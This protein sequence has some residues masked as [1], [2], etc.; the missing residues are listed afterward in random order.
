M[1]T[2]ALCAAYMAAIAAA[3]SQADAASQIQAK[4]LAPT[5]VQDLLGYTPAHPGANSDI[6][7]LS[8]LTTFSASG[9]GSVGGNLSVGGSAI[10]LSPSGNSYFNGGY[11]GI[12]YAPGQSLTHTLDLVGTFGIS[13]GG[14]GAM[15]Q[16]GYDLSTS[17]SPYE[18]VVT[19]AIGGNNTLQIRNTNTTNGYAAVSFRGTDPWDVNPTSMYERAAVGWSNTGIFAI[20]ASSFDNTND[21]GKPPARIS[22]QQSGAVDPTGGTV[23]FCNLTA[24]SYTITCSGNIPAS[25]FTQVYAFQLPHDTTLTAGGGTTTGMLSNKA[26]FTISNALVRF[27]SPTWTQ[28]SVF[29]FS[30]DDLITVY[31]WDVTP[32][33]V[34]SRV[35]HTFQVAGGM[36]YAERQVNTGC[37]DTATI[38]DHFVDWNSASAC[39]KAQAIEG[40][41]WQISGHE[42]VIN[43]VANTAGTYNIVITPQSGTINNAAS[44]AIN[45]TTTGH[46]GRIHCDGVSNWVLN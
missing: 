14:G 25:G 17:F 7:S 33:T 35:S 10:L 30:N 21:P 40:C 38:H 15:T 29:D 43:D 12:G 42:T 26:L 2:L 34:W 3:I 24:G 1:R 20:E 31:N 27:W 28:R 4:Q 32:N 9:N 18:L 44:Y 36:R 16:L 45:G 23:L 5:T 37:S 41:T 8:A 22:I 46:V 39:A 19:S 11:V 13:N 6:T